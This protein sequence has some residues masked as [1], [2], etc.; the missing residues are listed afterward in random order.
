[1]NTV[2][3][4]FRQ[5]IAEA[6]F[7]INSVRPGYKVVLL[8][9]E[10]SEVDIRADVTQ[11]LIDRQAACLSAS[12]NLEGEAPHSLDGVSQEDRKLIQQ[13]VEDMRAVEGLER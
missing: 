13:S 4:Q 12:I 11:A 6:Q 10:R 9:D 3:E 8:E 2:R 1:M 7:K 5:I